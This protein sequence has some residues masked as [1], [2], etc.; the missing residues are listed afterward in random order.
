[1]NRPSNSP[2]NTL[3]H[4]AIVVLNYNSEHDLMVL[5]PQLAA[6]TGTR[7]TLILVDNASSPASVVEIKRWLGAWRPDAVA[8]TQAEVQAWVESHS[9]SANGAGRIYL[10]THHENRG[11]S[12]GNNIGIQ[13]ASKLSADA[14][15]IA[16]PD[17]RI[18]DPNYV[19]TLAEKLFA[20]ENSCI[21]ASR[22]VGLN[23]EDQNPLRESTFWEELLWPLSTVRRWLK[24]DGYVQKTDAYH[25]VAVEKVSGC[26][27]LLRMTFLE[28]NGWLDENVFLYCEEPIL[29]AKVRAAHGVVLYVP[30][31]T[32]I[33]AHVASVKG[34]LS[35]RMTT[36]IASRKYYLKTYGDYKLWQVVLLELSYELLLIIHRLRG[37]FFK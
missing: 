25:A 31:L 23:G 9:V 29:S 10:I 7:T 22:I 12:A 27:L 36:F 19:A 14:V 37:V 24:W 15:L 8:G 32:A 28:L 18:G 16:N 3:R 4:I 21:A 11:Y 17:M 1:M 13:L 30:S 34:H 33:H 26:C 35:K 5:T 20:V 6:Q 2:C